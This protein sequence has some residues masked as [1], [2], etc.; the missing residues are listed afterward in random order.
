M[1]REATVTMNADVVADRLIP[2]AVA[3][4]RAALDEK[5]L[6]NGVG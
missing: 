2:S 6:E 3:A 5:Q 1:P 4:G